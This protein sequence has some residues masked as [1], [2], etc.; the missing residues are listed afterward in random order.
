MNVFWEDEMH[1]DGFLSNLNHSR[2]RNFGYV[3]S[4]T[5]TF[6]VK[7]ISCVFVKIGK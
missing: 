6:V 2:Q 5:R 7:Q 1:A 4:K 3:P